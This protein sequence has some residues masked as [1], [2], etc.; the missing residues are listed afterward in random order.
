MS[1][2][3]LRSNGFLLLFFL[4]AVLSLCWNKMAMN[5]IPATRIHE[6]WIVRY[7]GEGD[8]EE[9]PHA[10]AVDEDG[11]VYITG[12]SYGLGTNLDMTTVKYDTF[13][14]LL[15]V[16][17]Y[18]GSAHYID[19]ARALAIDE[20]G[21]V[22]VVGH[23]RLSDI[24]WD[25]VTIK[26]N[27]NGY[28]LWIAEY[29]GTGQESHLEGDSAMDVVVD[30]EGNVYVTGKSKES[31]RDYDYTTIKYDSLG[32]E[33]WIVHYDGPGNYW[34]RAY[35]ITMDDNGNIYVTG[36]SYGV[37]YDYATLKYDNNGN[38]M[39]VARYNGPVNGWDYGR[40]VVVDQ[41]GNVYVTGFSNRVVYGDRDYATIKY[42]SD[43]NQLWAARYNGPGN[44][45]DK[46]FSIVVDDEGYVYVN[47][48]SYGG[49]ITN[50]DFATIKYSPDGDEVW[51][52]RYNGPGSGGDRSEDFIL[53]EQGNIY[54]TG[55]SVGDGPGYDY[56]TIKYDNDGN[57]K[58]EIRYNGLENDDDRGYWIDL[59]SS[60][61]VYV[62]G[63]SIGEYD[64]D[65]VTIKYSQWP[66]HHKIPFNNLK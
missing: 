20:Y 49:A 10:I 17:K 26:Y 36:K 7:N 32:N 41:E 47:G 22:Y 18:D 37:L 31:G 16:N 27:S 8:G 64:Y 2:G 38:Q 66:K 11:N 60:G 30:N 46:A 45:D 61:N 58:W 1:K 15:W 40:D 3:K 39:W 65:F 44:D 43:G 35:A 12:E 5:Q 55:R 6:D 23:T 9:W 34:D 33:Q 50:D 63:Q 62:T 42:D 14:D 4:F 21:N 13:G 19:N 57:L 48:D 54:I 28:E 29:D 56:A 51:V 24:N 53:D 52:A 59:D 25:Y